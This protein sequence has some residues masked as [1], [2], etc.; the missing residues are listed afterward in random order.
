MSLL[1]K[2]RVARLVARSILEYITS[3]DVQRAHEILLNISY[4]SF[5]WKASS[6]HKC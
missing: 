2:S 4:W 1:G 6:Y 3:L 5:P